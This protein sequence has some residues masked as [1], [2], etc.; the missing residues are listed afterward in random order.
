MKS[1]TLVTDMASYVP[2][3]ISRRLTTDVTPTITPASE[4]LP[5]AALFADISEFTPLTEGLTRHGPLGTEELTRILN[6]Y[7]GQLI[8]LVLNHGGDVVKFAGDGLLA[9]WWADEETL[10]EA[11][12]YAVQCGLAIQIVMKPDAWSTSSEY[13][14]PPSLGVRIGIGAGTITAMTIGGVFGRWELL[15][16]GAPLVQMNLAQQRAQPG[17][18]VMSAEAWRLVRDHCTADQL[19]DGNRRLET[20]NN[21]LP[22]HSR[23]PLCLSPEAESVLRSYMPKAVLTRLGAGQFS[24]LAE[25]RKVTVLFINLPDLYENASLELA[26]TALHAAQT[27]LYRYEGSISRLGID[28]KG[29]TLVAA[30]GLPPLA[31]EDDAIRGVQA[32]LAI[33]DALHSLRLRNTIGVTTGQ[34]FCGAV[35]NEIR[36]EY[37]MMGLVV[38]LSARLM[39]VVDQVIPDLDP[40]ILCDS[41]TYEATQGNLHFKHVQKLHLRGVS[42]P[43]HIYRPIRREQHMVVS[44]ALRSATLIGRIEERQMLFERVQNLIRSQQGGVIILEGEAG[45]GKT[46]LIEDLRRSAEAFGV[47]IWQGAGSAIEQKT[48]YYAWSTI[49]SRLLGLEK[50]SDQERQRQVFATL[51]SWDL[52]SDSWFYRLIPLLNAVLPLDLTESTLTAQM[53]SQVRAKNTRDLLLRLLQMA[54]YQAPSILLLE[55][56][57]WLDSASWKLALALS[58]ELAFNPSPRLPLLLVLVLRSAG[59]MKVPDYHNIIGLPGILHRHLE[60][61][62]ESDIRELLQQRL[63]VQQVHPA[64]LKVIYEKTQGNPFFS[65]EL[66]YALYDSNLIAIQEEVCYFTT[67][68]GNQRDLRLPDTVQGVIIS[69]IDRLT[70]EEQ[71]TLKIASVIGVNI[72][73]RI[74]HDVHPVAADRD[75][76]TNYLATLE[77]AGLISRV[78]LEPEPM[79]NFKQT[80]I[81]DVVYN[82]MSFAQR[83]QLH[84]AVAEWY[85]HNY[86]DDPESHYSLLAYHWSKA[87]ESA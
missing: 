77:L 41:A 63:G 38:N 47:N 58:H 31:H 82:L 30:L 45:I 34:T 10:A 36:R 2:D 67:G 85:A 75:H 65:E 13:T 76:L 53:S 68:T 64:V 62:S 48:P 19:T 80:I 3:L 8:E 61:L 74:L 7:F 6:D 9:I 46:R 55:D 32:A 60:G 54:A 11:T 5:A 56:A 24:W 35:G 33:H 44:S 70:P 1:L 17:D 79:Y 59:D 26:Q 50:L 21:L 83:R 22:L 18:V 40:A 37:T 29:P 72:S 27:A 73:F 49:F 78:A 20:I 16:T 51:R 71:L 57:H 81:R 12:L 4:Q 14:I 84:R 25:W 15:V 86:T 28:K 39:Q 69:R 23:P 42:E 66:A 43:V 52:V 87:E